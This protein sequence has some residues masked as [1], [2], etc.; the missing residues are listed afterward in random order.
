M[1]DA[2][3]AGW[4]STGSG[5]ERRRGDF[6]TNRSGAAGGSDGIRRANGGEHSRGARGGRGAARR[7]R[8]VTD[9]G[10]KARAGSGATE[11]DRDAQTEV[12]APAT[13][14]S[15]PGM[16]ATLR[17]ETARPMPSAA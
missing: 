4:R 17:E 2:S 3:G 8:D 10:G 5:Q 9:G 15:W 12:E 13:G 7:R 16:T 6:G 11:R 14:G 1:A